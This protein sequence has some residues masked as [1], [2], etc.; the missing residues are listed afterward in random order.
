MRNHSAGGGHLRQNI[1]YGF[2]C[3]FIQI[4]RTF[5]QQKKLRLPVQSP[6]QSRTKGD[7]L[8]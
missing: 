2:F 6:R 4:C 5:V 3:W 8:A 7:R 1:R